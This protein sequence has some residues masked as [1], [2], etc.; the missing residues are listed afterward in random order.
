MFV[1]STEKKSAISS[2]M[3]VVQSNQP[4]TKWL[5]DVPWEWWHIVDLVLVSIAGRLG[6]HNGHSQTG[7]CEHKSMLLTSSY[8]TSSPAKVTTFIMSLLG[9]GR[10]GWGKRLINI[11]NMS[12]LVIKIYFCWG[13]SLVNNHMTHKYLYTLCPFWRVLSTFHFWTTCHQIFQLCSF[14][15]SDYPVKLLATTQESVQIHR[16]GHFS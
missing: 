4:Y 8:T 9:K 14:Q 13:C 12:Q 2:R 5:A 1:Y 6:I 16:F 7:L 11:H 15:V 10:D 3:E